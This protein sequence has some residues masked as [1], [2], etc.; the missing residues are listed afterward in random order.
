MEAQFR[1]EDSGNLEDSRNI[2]IYI[3]DK[4]LHLVIGLPSTVHVHVH[5]YTVLFCNMGHCYLIEL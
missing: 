3:R 1:L 2:H 4:V 5:N